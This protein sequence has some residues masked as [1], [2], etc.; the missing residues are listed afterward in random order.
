MVAYPEN[1]KME[2]KSGEV[3]ISF[4]GLPASTVLPKEKWMLDRVDAELKAG[5]RVMLF[6]WHEAVL[7]RLARLVER[8][9]SEPCAL[10]VAGKVQAAK[11]QDWIDEKVIKPGRRVLAVNGA[12]VQTGLNNLVHF[13]TAIWMQNPGVNPITKRQAEVAGQRKMAVEM[14]PNNPGSCQCGEGGLLPRPI[15][16]QE[17]H[18]DHD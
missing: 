18:H 10:L 8:E 13:H 1:E 9:L 14:V 6:G 16:A 7:P 2:T 15:A 17:A 12:A 5:R 3:L 4:P 11:R